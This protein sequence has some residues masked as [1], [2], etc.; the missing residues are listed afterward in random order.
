MRGSYCS[1]SSISR[2]APAKSRSLLAMDPSDACA[3]DDVGTSVTACI[4]CCFALA[5]YVGQRPHVQIQQTVRIGDAGMGG[6]IARIRRKRRLEIADGAPV[7]PFRA[8]LVERA[9][10]AH[11]RDGRR[12]R[13]GGA[14]RRS[15][16]LDRRRV[17]RRL[18]SG[19]PR[20]AS[21]PEPSANNSTM[22]VVLSAP[23]ITI[24]NGPGRT[25]LCVIA[26]PRQVRASPRSGTR[27]TAVSAIASTRQVPGVTTDW[28]PFGA[29]NRGA[30]T[31]T[32]DCAG[33]RGSTSANDG[34]CA[35]QRRRDCDCAACECDH[36]RGGSFIRA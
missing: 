8:L 10:G 29:A 17:E 9:S 19:R 23:R 36:H 20:T 15:A 24:A 21:N 16:T 25:S 33:T 5:M 22:C 12:R 7:A 31:T 13:R 32:I 27:R 35:D 4:A 28:P 14:N 1:A 26:T 18:D 2:R 30:P 34:D 6:G 11:E 3:S